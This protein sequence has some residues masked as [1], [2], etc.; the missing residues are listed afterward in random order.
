MNIV[1]III[2]VELQS[3]PSTAGCLLRCLG[4]LKQDGY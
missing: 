2:I 3:D 4:A 1:I